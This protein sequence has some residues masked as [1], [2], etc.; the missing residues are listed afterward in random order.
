VSRQRPGAPR[1]TAPVAQG[2]SLLDLT[3]IVLAVRRKRRMWLTLSL[4]GMIA[5]GL[6]SVLMP[7]APTAVVTVL[8]V[9]ENDLPS[10]TGTLMRTDVAVLQTTRIAG[11]ALKRLK[12]H[13]DPEE[14]LKTY[15]GNGLTNNV[16]EIQVEAASTAAAVRHAQALADA[17]IADH[18]SRTQKTAN[19]NAQALLDERTRTQAE[20]AK[21]NSAITAAQRKLDQAN[22][23]NDGDG[24]PDGSGGVSAA[25][26]ESLYARRAELTS[27]ISDLTNR[28][29]TASIGAPQVKAGTQI[30]DPPRAVRESRLMNTAITA[31]IGLAVGF[32]AGI[33]LAL[34]GGVVRDKPVLRADISAHL[35]ASV[36][37][38]CLTPRRGL[39]RLWRGSRTQRERKRVAGTLARL[40]R[41]GTTPV[42]VLELGAPRVAAALTL[43]VATNL[44]ADHDVVIVED[45]AGRVVA[46]DLPGRNLD[47]LTGRADRPIRIVG[48]DDGAVGIVQAGP[49]ELRLGI[50]SI[51]PG[52]AWTDLRHLGGE[53]LLVVRTGFANTAWLHT[54]AR[55]LADLQIP[56]IGV[57]LVDPDPRDKSDGTLWDGLHT[58]LRGRGRPAAELEAAPEP[59]NEP[60]PAEPVARPKPY[61]PRKPEWVPEPVAKATPAAAVEADAEESTSDNAAPATDGPAEH[62]EPAAKP[63]SVTASG[64]TAPAGKAVP[65][66]AHYPAPVPANGVNGARNDPDLPTKRF[67]PVQPH[68]MNGDGDHQSDHQTEHKSDHKTEQSVHDLPTKRFAPV[69]P[70]DVDELIH[71]KRK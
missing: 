51:N 49:G 57:V 6:V 15:K 66:P 25:D 55:Q 9:H 8:V 37:G 38:Q 13:E 23:D 46:D 3:R 68:L 30:V 29:E 19:A 12:S 70:D 31:G 40:V 18:V 24:V 53:T 41:G 33:T 60:K 64:P 4:L 47:E 5:G 71:R 50:G 39:S 21:V 58:A 28:A 52:T 17:F 2:E 10:E 1:R 59:A 62:A 67:A 35:G 20:L 63:E 69:R 34:V 56:I 16:M 27:K 54:V 11:D 43:D 32:A 36:V 48:A 26:T 45:P 7:P 42:S 65:K 22:Q 61:P 44:A 14:F